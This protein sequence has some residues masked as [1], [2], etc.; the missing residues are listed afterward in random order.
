LAR[1]ARNG[2]LADNAQMWASRWSCGDPICAE[3]KLSARI[4]DCARTKTRPHAIGDL[5]QNQPQA[6]VGFNHNRVLWYGWFLSVPKNTVGARSA[7]V[8]W[9]GATVH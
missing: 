4:T 6:V 9:W 3:E 2:Q 7:Q 1:A 8:Y 5:V